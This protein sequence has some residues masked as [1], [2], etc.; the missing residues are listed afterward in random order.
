[1]RNYDEP[2]FIA[3]RVGEDTPRLY[4]VRCYKCPDGRGKHFRNIEERGNENWKPAVADGTCA[5]C[6]W[7]PDPDVVAKLYQERS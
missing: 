3:Q 2:N 5:W 1:M 6:N 4:L 7:K